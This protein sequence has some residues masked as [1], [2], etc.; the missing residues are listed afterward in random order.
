MALE[1]TVNNEEEFENIIDI[2]DKE[3]SLEIVKV[4]LKNLKGRKKHHHVL[5]IEVLENGSIYDITID[6]ADFEYTL[7]KQL[8]VLEKYELFEE[9]SQVV[10]AL[11]YLKEK[12]K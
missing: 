5:S 1:L 7:G 10:E 12:N 8:S 4:I 2:H 9:C 6:R 11:N 3:V